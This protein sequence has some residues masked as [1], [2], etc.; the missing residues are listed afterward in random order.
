MTAYPSSCPTVVY[1]NDCPYWGSCGNRGGWTCPASAG[2]TDTVI[3]VFESHHT[4]L[5][6]AKK[7]TPLARKVRLSREAAQYGAWLIR[8]LQPLPKPPPPRPR[9]RNRCCSGSSKHM[10]RT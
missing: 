10:V 9:T 6:L 5:E 7:E 3:Y 1:P 8:K 4:S 2:T